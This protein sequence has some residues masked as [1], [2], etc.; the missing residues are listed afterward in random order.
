MKLY[1]RFG[2]LNKFHRLYESN[3]FL[4]EVLTKET[5]IRWEFEE[6]DKIEIEKLL[7]GVKYG[8]V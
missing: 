4:Q 5:G 1:I 3:E 7:K 2:N 6:S 8:M